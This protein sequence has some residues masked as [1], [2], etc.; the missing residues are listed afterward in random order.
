MQTSRRYLG[1]AVFAAVLFEPGF[2]SAYCRTTTCI[3]SDTD[4]CEYTAE[5][6]NISGEPLYW[7]NGCVSLG[8]HKD[9][10]LSQGITFEQSLVY[11]DEACAEWESA[12]CAGATP[13]LSVIPELTPLY[14]GSARVNSPEP[15][16]NTL[17]YID[18]DWPFEDPGI[19]LA[20]TTISFDPETGEILDADI[21]INTA[22]TEFQVEGRVINDLQ[23]VIVHEIGHFLGL[24]HSRV[25]DAT[26]YENYSPGG[27]NFR[28]ISEDDQAGIC[29]VYPPGAN[30]SCS[31]FV[32]FNGFS[33]YC[34][35]K[36]EEGGCSVAS[37]PA[38]PRSTDSG[39]GVPVG[40]A[41][42]GL[43]LLA[44]LR[45]RSRRAARKR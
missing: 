9:G 32:P 31:E 8:V 42:L 7:A 40:S 2:A 23:S 34:Q 25:R 43:G 14:C 17:L 6:C 21:E 18:E 35:E 5:G 12:D 24:S 10:S 30:E 15:N 13:S 41:S 19:T 33:P 22:D 39:G 37:L 44:W 3:A 11:V 26:M 1:W 16:A 20:L 29:A 4:T 38:T 36:M 45:L 27:T 28:T